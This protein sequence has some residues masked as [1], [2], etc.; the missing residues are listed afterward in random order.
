MQLERQGSGGADIIALSEHVDYWN[1]LGWADAYSSP[2]FSYRQQTYA[3]KFHLDSVY[4]PQ[5]VIDGRV[6]SVGSDERKVYAAIEQA[7]HAPRASVRIERASS[8]SS[9][10]AESQRVRVSVD[11][12]PAPIKNETFDVMLAVTQSGVSSQVSRGENAGRVLRHTGVVRTMT[13]VADVNPR[14]SRSYSAT[15][16]VPL[17][18]GHGRTR[19]VVF[20]Q[21]RET[22]IIA[23]A[24]SCAV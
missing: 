2:L 22:Q 18:H 7:A 19:V 8:E 20:V 9:D 11:A 5:M 23:G 12:I 6:E 16:M 24:A 15:L 21:S 14:K 10:N 17:P 1:H 3:G 4:T 13:R